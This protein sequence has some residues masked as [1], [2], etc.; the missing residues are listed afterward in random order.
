MVSGDIM[1]RTINRAIISGRIATI[2]NGKR[3]VKRYN[4]G[5]KLEGEIIIEDTP[6]FT[7]FVRK[8]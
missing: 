5:E 3:I 2:K 1:R 4:S 8:L 6:P 7:G